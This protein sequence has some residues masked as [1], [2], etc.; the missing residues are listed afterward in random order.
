MLY[1][2]LP[3]LKEKI[4]SKLKLQKAPKESLEAIKNS[5]INQF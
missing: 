2:T 4:P 1:Q 3:Y 5:K